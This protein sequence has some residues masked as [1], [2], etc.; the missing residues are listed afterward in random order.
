MRLSCRVQSHCA[1]GK[2]QKAGTV[3]ADDGMT[4]G[5]GRFRLGLPSAG[6]TRQ[7]LAEDGCDTFMTCGFSTRAAVLEPSPGADMRPRSQE[8]EAMKAP[9]IPTMTTVGMFIAAIFAVAATGVAQAA[10]KPPLPGIKSYNFS[11]SPKALR[12]RCHRLWKGRYWRKRHFYGCDELKIKVGKPFRVM[13]TWRGLTA[14]PICVVSRNQPAG[15]GGN[16]SPS[17]GSNGGQSGGTPGGP[18]GGGQTHRP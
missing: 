10:A 2:V 18:F 8:D 11:A 16:G 12:W 5:K 15:G 17:G 14:A 9:R 6:R 4:R 7:V 3:T 13:C 1:T